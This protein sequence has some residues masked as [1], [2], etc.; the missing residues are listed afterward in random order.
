MIVELRNEVHKM[1]KK[2]PR[3]RANI[4]TSV[5][6]DQTWLINVFKTHLLLATKPNGNFA[7][8]MIIDIL[9]HATP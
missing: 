7:F 6:Q 4:D 9:S 2:K 5:R 8:Q 1:S 3:K